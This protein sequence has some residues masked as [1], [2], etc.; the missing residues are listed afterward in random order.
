MHL[1]KDLSR[2]ACGKDGLLNYLKFIIYML[3]K[4]VS[5]YPNIVHGEL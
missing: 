1:T 5:M 3:K 4:S 2:E